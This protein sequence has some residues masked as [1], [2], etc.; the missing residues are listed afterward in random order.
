MRSGVMNFIAENTKFV[1]PMSGQIVGFSV[2]PFKNKTE[3]PAVMIL[4]INKNH[5]YIPNK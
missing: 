5:M 1:R 2:L 4:M 3:Q